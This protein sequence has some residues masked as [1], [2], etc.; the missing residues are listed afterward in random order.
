[1]G[2]TGPQGVQGIQGIPGVRGA[3]GAVGPQGPQGLQGIQGATGATGPQ[4]LQGIQGPTGATGLQG[5]QGIQGATG[6]TGPQGLQGIQGPTGATGP[7]GLQGIQGP[8]G[9]T[10]PQGLQGI[11]G[12]TGATGPQGPAGQAATVTI[13]TVRT[14]EPNEPASVVNRGNENNAVLDFVIPQGATG[15]T[16]PLASLAISDTVAKNLSS[17]T[18][19]IFTGQPLLQTAQFSYTPGTAEISINQSGIYQLWFHCVASMNTG[20]VIP[21]EIEM[22]VYLN[23]TPI[24]GSQINRTFTTS[25]E[26]ANLSLSVPFQTTTTDA[27]LVIYVETGG[28]TISESSLT[29]IKLA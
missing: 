3:T 6:A 2:P 14:G 20:A 10:G 15:T 22:Q 28:F 24:P 9:A 5:L 12:P 4:G 8:T 16:A 11:Q 25:L 19:L 29:I 27:P 23:G 26:Q 18:P 17:R 21:S 13:G 1:M 7:Q